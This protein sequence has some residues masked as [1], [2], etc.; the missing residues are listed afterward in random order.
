MR[1][2]ICQLHK[3]AKVSK[4]QS[5]LVPFLHMMVTEVTLFFFYRIGGFDTYAGSC[6][7]IMNWM[8][9]FVQE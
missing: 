1:R 2:S 8:V 3:T 9:V 5:D 4:F 7:W 6:V